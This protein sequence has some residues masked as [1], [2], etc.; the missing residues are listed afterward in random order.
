MGAKHAPR[1]LA[2]PAPRL[3]D[4]RAL[5]QAVAARVGDFPSQREAAM[6]A[7]VAP[8]TLSRVL[9]GWADLSHENYLR[10]EAWLGEQ[11]AVAA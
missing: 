1:P 9:N 4:E 5:A 10:I 3:F 11:E 6:S 8:T 7:G 2:A